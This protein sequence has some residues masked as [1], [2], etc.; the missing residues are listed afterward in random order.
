MNITII[1][2][3][4]IKEKFFK[5][6]ISEYAKRIGPHAK[7]KLVELAQEQIYDNQINKSLDKQAH[8]IMKNIPKA[9]Y[10]VPLAIQV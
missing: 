9:A 4:K 2:I 5:D 1:Y 3:G 6:A 10:T 8:T 7:L